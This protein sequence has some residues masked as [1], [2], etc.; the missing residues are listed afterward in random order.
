MPVCVAAF[1]GEHHLPECALPLTPE[2]RD[3]TIDNTP[4]RSE[5][6]DG[7][8]QPPECASPLATEVRDRTIDNMS[9]L[10]AAFAGE[11]HPPE[12]ASPLTT[13]LRDGTIDNAPV[14]GAAFAGEHHPLECIS[15]ESSSP[16]ATEN[17]SSFRSDLAAGDTGDYTLILANDDKLVYASFYHGTMPTVKSSITI[18]IYGDVE[19]RVHN[20]LVHEAHEIWDY[21]PRHSNTANYVLALSSHLKNYSVC[22]GNPDDDMV[23]LAPVGAGLTMPD[24]VGLDA[25]KEGNL[26][27]QAGNVQYNST[28]RHTESA[29][30]VEGVHWANCQHVWE[31]LRSRRTR[32]RNRSSTASKSTPNQFLSPEEKDMKL[33]MLATARKT[34]KRR[35]LVLEDRVE[36]L[37]EKVKSLIDADGIAVP[38]GTSGDIIKLMKE[39]ERHIMKTFGENYFQR[40]FFEQQVKYNELRDKKEMIWHSSIIHWCLYLRSKSAKAY[41][42]MRNLLALP[43][44]RTLFDYSITSECHLFR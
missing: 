7:E 37:D 26:H 8:H 16:P 30:L 28:I 15:S 10:S 5:A 12:C 33:K 32:N 4:V 43:S 22:V 41:D 24:S 25:Y 40:V 19:L 11:H 14:H 21:L 20:R 17:F 13:E 18:M 3:H 34:M 23:S 38:Q 29:L 35:I 2:L 31:R 36:K 9:V 44:E 6:F 39:S 42:G 1:S 27:A